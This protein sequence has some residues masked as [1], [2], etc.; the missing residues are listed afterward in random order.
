MKYSE[1]IIQFEKYSPVKYLEH[2]LTSWGRMLSDTENK[3]SYTS[4]FAV[5]YKSENIDEII[6]EVE[7]YYDS[8]YIVPKI[9]NRCG[10]VELDILKPYFINHGYAIREFDMEFMI[11]DV[12]SMRNKIAESPKIKIISSV[13]DGKERNLAVEQDNGETYGV[14]LLSKQLSSG[15]DMFFAYDEFKNPVSMALAEKYND[16]VYISDVYTTPSSRRK[17]Y[18]MAVVNSIIQHYDNPLIYLY[19][20]NPEAASIYRKLGFSGERISSWWAIKG[21]LPEWCVE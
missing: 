1:Q 19:T 14:K 12:N 2:K 17:G 4:N 11:L 3:D 8:R 5:I 21:S 15:N 7:E 13:L 9:F 16:V 18:G 20:D 10:S 6:K